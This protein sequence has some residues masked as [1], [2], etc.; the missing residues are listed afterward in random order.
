MTTKTSSY[1]TVDYQKLDELIQQRG[2]SRAKCAAYCGMQAGTL[3]NAFLRQSK[4]KAEYVRLLADFL[5]VKPLD[6][7]KKD[8]NGNLYGGYNDW[9]AV[10]QKDGVSETDRDLEKSIR[11]SFVDLCE[12]LNWDGTEKL[13]TLSRMISDLIRQIPKYRKDSDSPEATDDE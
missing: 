8:E 10:T 13:Y 5:S 11:E 2:T 6:L 7:L 9:D 3:G 1:V 4:M 12:E